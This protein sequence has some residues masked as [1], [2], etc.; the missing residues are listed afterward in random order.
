M[1]TFSDY[2]GG[3]FDAA[4]GVFSTIADIELGRAEVDLEKERRK[5]EAR[6]LQ[7]GLLTTTASESTGVQ[8]GTAEFAG[9]STTTLLLAAGGL[10]LLLLLLRK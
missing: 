5:A 10:V 1:E 7:S 3:L 2:L 6:A 4:K 9:I 8:V